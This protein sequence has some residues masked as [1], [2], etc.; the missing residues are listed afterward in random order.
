M[1]M[2]ALVP[3]YSAREVRAFPEDRVRY[4]AHRARHTL[5]C[6]ISIPPRNILLRVPAK[7]SIRV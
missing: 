5:P 4:T 6:A 1:V 2:S 7:R 3:G